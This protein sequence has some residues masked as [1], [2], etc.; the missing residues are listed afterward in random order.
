MFALNP[1]MHCGSNSEHPFALVSLKTND[2]TEKQNT[3]CLQSSEANI[4]AISHIPDD[5][6][7]SF[8]QGTHL[9]K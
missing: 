2:N 3:S 5:K 9:Q 4:F 1:T 7:N 8:N 6:P